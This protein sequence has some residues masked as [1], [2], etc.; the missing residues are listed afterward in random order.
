MTSESAG[1]Y[2]VPDAR[3]R[4]QYGVNEVQ[5][6]ETGKTH[7]GV[8]PARRDK[9]GIPFLEVHPVHAIATVAQPRRLLPL[10][11]AGPLLVRLQVGRR[12]P[13][14]E[15]RLA[16]AQDV[17]KHGR[18]GKVDVPVLFT[19]RG[20][21]APVQPAEERTWTAHSTTRT[22]RPTPLDAH[23]TVLL[24]ARVLARNLHVFGPDRIDP[25]QFPAGKVEIL[26][27]S[28]TLP[29]PPAAP[30]QRLGLGSPDEGGRRDHL[31]QFRLAHFERD[32]VPDLVP[33]RVIVVIGPLPE[34]PIRQGRL[35]RAVDHFERG[36]GTFFRRCV[37]RSV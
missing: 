1:V 11:R 4:N 29:P 3:P 6:E 26:G 16:A 28:A 33:L 17:V 5:R 15:E 7:D 2:C 10:R 30:R 35:G 21:S 31:S 24:D 34:R 13:D 36:V 32:D 8:D 18:T 12:R 19:G 37:G 25:V 23:Q 27:G 14:K 22:H 20:R 9:G